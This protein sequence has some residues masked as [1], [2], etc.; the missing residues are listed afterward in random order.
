[1]RRKT[2]ENR[3]LEALTHD[4]LYTF[5]FD[6]TAGIVEEEIVSRSGVNFTKQ[7]GLE[8]PCLFDALVEKAFG[9]TLKCRYTSESAVT[10]LSR[11]TLLDAYEQGKTKLEANV[12]YIQ[13]NQYVRITYLLSRDAE[14]GHILAYVFCDDVTG[15]EQMRGDAL[16]LDNANLQ[17]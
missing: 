2:R 10:N 9:D 4:S 11:Q 15:L 12:H 13:R 3:L 8:A 16:H 14:N 6:V 1:M 5:E 7:L 17:R